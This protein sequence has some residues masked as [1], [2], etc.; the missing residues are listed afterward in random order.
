M[1]DLAYIMSDDD[2]HTFYE[3]DTADKKKECSRE[4][5][6]DHLVEVMRAQP[7]VCA[8]GPL[9]SRKWRSTIRTN[10]A[11]CTNR[12]SSTVEQFVLVRLCPITRAASYFPHALTREMQFILAGLD[13]VDDRDE[14]PGYFQGED[15]GFAEQLVGHA[16]VAMWFSINH[17]TRQS[18][19][20]TTK[21][22]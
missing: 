11:G 13:P 18:V 19:V 21:R 10:D 17:E 9:V 7:Q 15:F 1:H 22:K 12:Y 3:W 20:G 2:L 16:A 4:I 6:I 8:I 5:V 14:Y